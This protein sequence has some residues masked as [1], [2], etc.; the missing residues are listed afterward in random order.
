MP[1][2]IHL[3][4]RI[5]GLLQSDAGDAPLHPA[6]TIIIR[7]LKSLT[8]RKAGF[9]LWQDSFYEHVIRSDADYQAIWNYI[10]DNPRKWAEDCYYLE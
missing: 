3:L 6:L 2:H 5:D 4:L 10:E 8:T 1:N 9:P 7:G